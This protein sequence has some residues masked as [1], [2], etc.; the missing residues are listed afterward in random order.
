MM[1]WIFVLD[2]AHIIRRR[3]TSDVYREPG[4]VAHRRG[5]RAGRLTA[6]RYYED[7]PIRADEVCPGINVIL[8]MYPVGQRPG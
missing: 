7:V 6:I 8:V 1:P 5:C 4:S 2:S 3:Q